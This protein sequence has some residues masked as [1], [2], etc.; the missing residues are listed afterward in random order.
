M[1]DI[2]CVT[3]H[4]LCKEDYFTRIEQIA[5]EHPK[6]IL[7]REKD[8]TE[9]E[10][11]SLAKSVLKI[12]RRYQTP[13][14]LHSFVGVAR[15]LGWKAI[16]LPLPLLRML[17]DDEKIM[18]EIIGSSCHSVE[19]AKEAENLGCTYL[20]AGHIFE[21][22]CKKDL[23]ARGFDFLEEICESVSIPVYAIGGINDQNIMEIRK[24]K[25]SGACI[26]SGIMTCDNPS[27]YLAKFKEYE[28]EIL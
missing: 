26:M 1:S 16:H 18:F 11:L 5:K 9:E 25:A 2:L 23:P 21:T 7:V 27:E 14:I 15:K 8:L 20:I 13:C 10:Y 12:C 28:N 22:D 24:S 6:G 4:K 3:N 19:E 17:R